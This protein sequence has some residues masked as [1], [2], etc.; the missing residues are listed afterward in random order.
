MS[1][2]AKFLSWILLYLQRSLLEGPLPLGNPEE[3]MTVPHLLEVDLVAELQRLPLPLLGELLLLEELG[4]GPLQL[5]H[6]LSNV[7]PGMPIPKTAPVE[8]GLAVVGVLAEAGPLLRIGRT[9]ALP[10]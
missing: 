1:F 6:T 9:M 8:S 2:S 4:K 10:Q 3:G 7:M 5:V